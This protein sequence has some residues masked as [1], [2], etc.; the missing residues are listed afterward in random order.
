TQEYE[1]EEVVP[2]MVVQMRDKT[3]PEDIYQSITAIRQGWPQIPPTAFAHVFGEHTDIQAGDTLVPYVEP[4]SV[5][6]RTD[7][8]V[9][10]AKTAVS[11]GWDCPRAEVMVSY[12]AA[13]DKAHITQVIG[14]MVRSPLARRINGNDLLNSVLCILPMFDQ[15]AATEVVQHINRDHDSNTEPPVR[16]VIDPETLVPVA[17]AALWDTFSS[18]PRVVA[19]KRSDKPISMLLN[20]GIELERDELLKG[21][22]NKAEK[23]LIAIVDGYMTRYKEKVNFHREDI[24]KVKT[25][26]LRFSYAD[27]TLI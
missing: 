2:L 5:Q 25:K 14:R 6:D 1:G 11:T 15:K 26:R 10:F 22:Q 27:R 4:Q 12:R 21:G 20:L 8:T 7:I 24:L 9:L 19:P 3:T 13:K 17:N 18:L 16:A 23:E